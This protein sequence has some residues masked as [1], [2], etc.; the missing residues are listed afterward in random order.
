MPK[1]VIESWR[2]MPHSY[3]LWAQYLALD[4]LTRP[5]IEVY[6]AEA[7]LPDA[8]WRPTRGILMPEQEQKLAEVPA[9]PSDL[10]A[11]LWLRLKFPYDFS[12][13]PARR[14]VVT[15][16]TEYG[17]VPTTFVSGGVPISQAAK[18][19]HTIA[20]CSAWSREGFLRSG[21]KKNQLVDLPLGADLDVFHPVD[22]ATRTGLRAALGW[23]DTFTLFHSSSLGWNKGLE[24]MLEALAALSGE[25]PGL[26]LAIK[27]VDAL[28]SSR[29]VIAGLASRLPPGAADLLLPRVSYTG[30]SLRVD[31]V[32]K[33]YQAADAY[34]APYLAEGF[35]MP[36]LEAAA[37]GLPVICTAGGSTDDFTNPDFTLRISSKRKTAPIAG[38]PLG[39][40][41]EPS[42]E[43]FIAQLRRAIRDASYR[44]QA[45]RAGPAFVAAGW[46]WKHAAD[47]L[48]TLLPPT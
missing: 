47:K 42:L 10:A 43:N 18:S 35:N 11:D 1:I 5:G 38:Q 20:T 34:I 27:G 39:L 13:A 2:F 8:R 6:W 40:F 19:G 7:P 37:C 45:R 33:F 31:G 3:A 28:Y 24:Y 46:T 22:E 36:V 23:S 41:L 32:A 9:P 21:I 12:A 25:C 17:V 16:T 48:L 30:E 14:V 15:G 26:R 4:L 29:D 44:T